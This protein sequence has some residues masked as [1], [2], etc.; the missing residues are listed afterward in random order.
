MAVA[1][2]YTR[3]STCPGGGQSVQNVRLSWADGT[4]GTVND[5]LLWAQGHFLVLA[6]GHLSPAASQ[7]LR[8][9]VRN[10]PVRVV[11]VVDGVGAAEAR[12]HVRDPRGHLRGACHITDQAWALV[13]PDSYLAATGV[14]IDSG[15][16]DALGAALGLTGHGDP[17]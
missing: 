15:L 14:A 16:V 9:L 5:L 2:P 13:R 17:E 6:F 10:A 7:R 12:E 4:T 1:N 8:A 3:A 11:Q